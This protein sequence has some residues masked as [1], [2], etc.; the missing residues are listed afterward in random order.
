MRGDLEL[1][2]LE[3]ASIARSSLGSANGHDLAA[4]LADDVVVMV[5]VGVDALEAGGLAAE[6]RRWTSPSSASCSSVR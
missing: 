2:A 1:A 4:A 5:A 3:T 6:S